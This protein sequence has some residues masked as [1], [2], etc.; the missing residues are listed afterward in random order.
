MENLVKHNHQ[1]KLRLCI[2]ESED[3]ST[4]TASSKTFFGAP[5]FIRLVA[6][7]TIKDI[8]H[9]RIHF[10]RPSPLLK[11]PSCDSE[12]SDQNQSL[13]CGI[14]TVL[15]PRTVRLS[16]RIDNRAL[17]RQ[18]RTDSETTDDQAEVHYF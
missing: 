8:K 14:P 3:T 7:Q 10:R 17:F 6:F 2:S 1:Q 12:S 9:I 4:P 18:Y 5:P 11:S 13:A 15:S 16:T